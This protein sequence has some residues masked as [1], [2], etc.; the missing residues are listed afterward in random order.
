[1]VFCELSFPWKRPLP[2]NLV[3]EFW[4]IIFHIPV[5]PCASFINRNSKQRGCVRLFIFWAEVTSIVLQVWLVLQLQGKV[6]NCII[7]WFI[8]QFVDFLQQNIEMASPTKQDP[9]SHVWPQSFL[10]GLYHMSAKYN[11]HWI[12]TKFIYLICLLLLLLGTEVMPKLTQKVSMI[13]FMIYIL[14]FKRGKKCRQ[15]YNLGG[16][17]RWWVVSL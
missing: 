3:F 14:Q 1:M 16:G 12:G 11:F 6:E 7:S 8:L 9:A 5:E 15:K 10:N 2:K 17:S 13:F 4:K